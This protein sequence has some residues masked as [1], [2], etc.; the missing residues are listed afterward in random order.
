MEQKEAEIKIIM[1]IIKKTMPKIRSLLDN[2]KLLWPRRAMQCKKKINYKSKIS[3][4]HYY[5]IESFICNT[6]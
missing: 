3:I 2:K 1:I 6:H 4:L 5:A